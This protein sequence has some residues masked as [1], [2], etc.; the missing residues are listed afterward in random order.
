MT[1]DSV[2]GDAGLSEGDWVE[3]GA[4]LGYEDQVGVADLGD[5]LHWHVAVIPPDTAPTYNG[6]YWDYVVESGVQPEVIPI[7]CHEGGASVLWRTGTYT[8]AGCPVKASLPAR[9]TFL[10]Q[11]EARSPL[12]AALQAI[13]T[14]TDE[15]I[16]L[17]LQDPRLMLKTR[18][19][20]ARMEADFQDLLRLGRAQVSGAELQ[21][22][23]QL[24][25][26]YESRGSTE[27]RRVLEPI[28]K[29]LQS[30][31]GRQSLGV[32]L[33]DRFEGLD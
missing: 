14:V 27:I 16:W 21:M 33:E 22:V 13:A 7:V 24:L 19:L 25:V 3:A 32:V 1:K 18:Q 20:F 12:A 5:H 26:E 11:Q 2:R 4:F 23:L 6:Y 29:Q 8:A 28:R 10:G 15:G 31:S 17:A 30:P 9:T